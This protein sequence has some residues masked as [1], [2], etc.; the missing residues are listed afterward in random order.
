MKDTLPEKYA[1]SW[2]FVGFLWSEFPN[3]SFL[4]FYVNLLKIFLWL[5]FRNK[6]VC[7]LNS[8]V[9]GRLYLSRLCTI[10]P[11][12]SSAITRTFAL[13]SVILVAISH[14]ISAIDLNSNKTSGDI[15]GCKGGIYLKIHNIHWSH[16]LH[17]NA[18]MV[19]I[20]K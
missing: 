14:K 6:I 7:H 4:S 1:P 9:N 15:S 3:N 10:V 20:D 19:A 18:N 16:T 17:K 2:W 12:F 11:E 13:N 5:L 8:C